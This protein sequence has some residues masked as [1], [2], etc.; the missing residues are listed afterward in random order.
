MR[1]DVGVGNNARYSG[2]TLQTCDFVTGSYA[3]N[4]LHDVVMR[5]DTILVSHIH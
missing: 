4:D 3:G 1:V 5:L 2:R